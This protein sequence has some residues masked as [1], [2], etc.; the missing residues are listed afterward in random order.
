M[1]LVKD[2]D[3]FKDKPEELKT[4]ES[5]KHDNFKQDEVIR[6]LEEAG[7]DAVV[8][9]CL[10][11]Y[12]EYDHSMKEIYTLLYKMGIITTQRIPSKKT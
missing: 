10:S 7:L 1:R 3:V 6:L 2:L 5:M 8:M 4:L 12:K 9:D 11:K